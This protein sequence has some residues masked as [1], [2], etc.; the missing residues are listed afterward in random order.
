MLRRLYDWTMG[1]AG[2]RN[3]LW[4]LF[5]ISFAESSVFPIP[6]DV[7]LIPMVL[8]RRERAWLIAGVCTVASVM[9]ALVGYGIG[10]FLFESVGRPLLEF[11]GHADQFNAF[12]SS[13]N[14][15]GAWI[16]AGGGFTPV[17]YKLINI[18]SG[19]TRLDLVVFVAASIVARSARFFLEAALLWRFGP[20]LQGVLE[21][22]LGKFAILFFVILIGSFVILRYVL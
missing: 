11:Y 15:W 18:S 10:V 4:A 9:G 16:V 12:Q 20:P 5:A 2:K 14:E 8:A 22:H 1:L 17:P 19:L 6:P 3:A 21:R 7:L 13:Y